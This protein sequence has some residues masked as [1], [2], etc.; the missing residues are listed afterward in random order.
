MKIRVAMWAIAGFLVA[1]CWAVYAFVTPPD[2]FL[3]RLREPVV[4][5]ALYLSCPVSYAGRYYPI[6]LWWV[7][8]I[9]AATFAAVGLML[10]MYRLKLRPRL[11]A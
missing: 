6:K 1:G 3:M 5:A 11:A 7:L 2:T 10:E 9:N 4:R 8:L